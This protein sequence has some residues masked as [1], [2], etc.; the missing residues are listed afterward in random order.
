M[1]PLALALAYGM[2]YHTY[3]AG[4]TV[5]NAYKSGDIKNPY[6]WG[7]IGLYSTLGNQ[8]NVGYELGKRPF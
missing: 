3:L 5:H 8:I 2:T 1:F 4:D 6:K 7:L